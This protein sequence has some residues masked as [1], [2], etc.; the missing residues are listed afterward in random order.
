MT[1][2][3]PSPH[4]DKLRALLGNEK[5]PQDDR[6][7]VQDAIERYEG[8][9]GE[10]EDV[11]ARGDNLVDDLVSLLNVYKL[12]I[13]V[14]LVFDSNNDFLYRQKGQLKIDNT[15]LEEFLPQLVGAVFSDQ[16]AEGDLILGPTNAFSQ[17]RF[18]S[19]LLRTTEAGGMA[20]RTKDHDFAMARPLYLRAS[21]KEDFSESR[22][23]RTHLAYVAAEIKTN[24]DKTMFQEA[25]GTAYDLKLALPYSRYFLLCEWLDM[26]PISTAV[27]AIEEVIV[28]R[29][30]KR[31]AANVR[32]R[33]STANGRR[34]NRDAFVDYLTA[35]AFAPQAFQRFL[36]HVEGLL[37]SGD[38]S[39]ADT[40]DR[41][42]F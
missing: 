14:D 3:Y 42:W 23:M 21:H 18:D 40:L 8:W 7:R 28:L 33:F 11:V 6:A 20:L 4:G 19:S 16:L 30:A 32:A 13:D 5:L 35:H 41:G 31:L 29:K 39:E 24:L 1:M 37:G 10:I 2:P 12:S 26:T 25:S 17:L 34:E 15:V 36:T 9:L 22:E 38:E 27:T